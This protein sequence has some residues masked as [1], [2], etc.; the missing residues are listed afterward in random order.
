MTIAI[1]IELKPCPFCGNE[2]IAISERHFSAFA[3]FPGDRIKYS[4]SCTECGAEAN[5]TEMWINGEPG[6]DYCE[7]AAAAWN[8]RTGG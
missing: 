2:H 3:S 1:E 4:V 5:G 7:Q 8:Y 6:F